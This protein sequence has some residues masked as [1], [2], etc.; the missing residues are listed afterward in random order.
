MS[1]RTSSWAS[2]P[3]NRLGTIDRRGM[4]RRARALLAELDFDLDPTTM[5]AGLSIGEVQFVEFAR[6]MAEGATRLLFLDEPT[7]ALTPAETD[8]LLR[9]AR[10][11]RDRG[12]SIVFISHRLEE[13]EGLVDRVTVLRDGRH[14]AT[15]PAAEV[16]EAAVIRLMVGRALDPIR[17]QGRSQLPVEP[18]PPLLAG[19]RPRP[20]RRVP[21]HLVRRSRR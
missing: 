21:G 7:A 3:L 13:L 1:P 19:A 8:R 2:Q 16:D 5:T 15:L 17:Q 9:V 12:T 10:R 11:L 18:G 14:V 6:A 20:A 4:Y